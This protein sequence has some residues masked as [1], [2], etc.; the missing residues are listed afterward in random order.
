M[1]EESVQLE[2]TDGVMPDTLHAARL[3]GILGSLRNSVEMLLDTDDGT[4]A[5]PAWRQT[6]NR[7]VKQLVRAIKLIQED[8]E[9]ANQPMPE[10]TPEYLISYGRGNR[11][12]AIRAP[13]AHPATVVRVVTET[14]S[15]TAVSSI[16]PYDI[17]R[18]QFSS[19]IPATF[20][21]YKSGHDCRFY[22]LTFD[23]GNKKEAPE[24]TEEDPVVPWNTSP[25]II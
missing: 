9:V 12:R 7:A 16:S 1:L 6:T 10:G 11:F 3:R 14:D 21:E 20:L 13:H 24:L 5:R 22:R 8:I 23:F 19:A 17:F 18:E 15:G 25:Q 2:D 4:N